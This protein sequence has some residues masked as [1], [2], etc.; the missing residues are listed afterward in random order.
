LSLVST[1]TA[2]EACGSDLADVVKWNVYAVE[3][4]PLQA[5]REAFMTAW[6]QRPNPPAITVAIAIGLARQEFLVEMD[7]VAE[8]EG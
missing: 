2:L 5:A 1:R 3:G 8:M 7:G 4:Q 6:G